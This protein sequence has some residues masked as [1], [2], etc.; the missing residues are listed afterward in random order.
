M[1]R[2]QRDP[3]IAAAADLLATEFTGKLFRWEIFAV[4]EPDASALGTIVMVGSMRMSV[5]R[6]GHRYP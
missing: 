1:C 4:A 5:E 2:T 3:F 6:G